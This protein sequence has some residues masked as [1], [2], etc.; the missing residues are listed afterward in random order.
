MENYVIG[1]IDKYEAEFFIYE[2]CM[3]Y[4]PSTKELKFVIYKFG[5]IDDGLINDY[6]FNDHEES[7]KYYYKLI[8]EELK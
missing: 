1:L 6:E 7:N 5:K 2:Y 3:E 8:K 4:L